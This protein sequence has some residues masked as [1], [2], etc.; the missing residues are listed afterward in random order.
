[1]DFSENESYIE[2]FN[3]LYEIFT[4]KNLI[5]LSE[6][7]DPKLFQKLIKEM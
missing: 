1:M 6:L 2:L 5:T 4:N 7:R 3:D